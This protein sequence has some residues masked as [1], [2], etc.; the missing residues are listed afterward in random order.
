VETSADA[1][2]YLMAG[3]TAVQVGA[4]GLMDPLAPLKVLGGLE[5]YLH[6]EGITSIQSLVGATL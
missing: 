4:A 6:K 1:A 3:A 5:S 2:A